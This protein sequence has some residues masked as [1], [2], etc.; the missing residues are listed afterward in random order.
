MENIWILFALT[1]IH[2]RTNT[3]THT[4]PY[5]CLF[6]PL[7][8]SSCVLFHFVFTQSLHGTKWRAMRKQL[9]FEVPIKYLRFFNPQE[10]K[11]I[12]S[13]SFQHWKL[14][15]MIYI[16]AFETGKRAQ[17][18]IRFVSCRTKFSILLLTSFNE[19]MLFMF[20]KLFNIKWP[21]TVIQFQFQAVQ[22]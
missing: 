17:S 11:K 18:L 5:S 7:I 4:H 8:Y 16:F 9:Q 13:F 14:Q 19:C 12:V 3:N 15:Q 2:K 1:Q 10:Q 20:Q 21:T 6:G 22:L